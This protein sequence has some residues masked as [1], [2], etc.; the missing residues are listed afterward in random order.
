MCKCVVVA[1]KRAVTK[2]RGRLAWEGNPL[3][4]AW[5]LTALAAASWAATITAD[6]LNLPG[7]IWAACLTAAGT[8]T[9]ATLQTVVVIERNRIMQS[10]ATAALTRPFYRNQTGPQPVIPPQPGPVSLDDRRHKRHGRHA[11]AQ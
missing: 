7:H 3:R 9:L 4:P 8:S 5:G 11:N 10:L 1:R 6:A 2:A